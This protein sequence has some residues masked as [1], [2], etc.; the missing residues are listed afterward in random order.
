MDP[1]NGEAAYPP[2]VG[3]VP[4]MEPHI[5]SVRKSAGSYRLG[6]SDLPS[7]LKRSVMARWCF[8]L[9]LSFLC[10]HIA[11]CTSFGGGDGNPFRIGLAFGGHARAAPLP[12]LYE[13][14]VPELQAGL[15]AGHFTSVDLIK[16]P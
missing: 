16:V 9:V 5:L 13:A 4:P 6:P 1:A 8:T 3:K 7:F 11:C 10:A 2:S 14:S 15:D 12:D